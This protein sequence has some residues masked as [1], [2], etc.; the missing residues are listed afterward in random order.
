[1]KDYHHTSNK[2]TTNAS[3]SSIII[4]KPNHQNF[5]I[6]SAAAIA[7]LAIEGPTVVAFLTFAKPIGLFFEGRSLYFKTAVYAG[8]TLIPMLL[9]TDSLPVYFGFIVSAAIVFMHGAILIGRKGSLDDMRAAAD[10]PK[11]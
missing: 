11:I 7:I 3:N 9:G 2:S 5:I 6:H 4:H 8:L 10:Q 1:M